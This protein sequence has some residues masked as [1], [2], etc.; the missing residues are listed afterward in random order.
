M[1]EYITQSAFA[2][3]CG[4]SRQALS[5]AIREG[6]VLKTSRGI[7]PAN[8]ANQYYKSEAG[9]RKA[10]REVPK[11]T[12]KKRKKAAPKKVRVKVAPPE[13]PE[14]II[15]DEGGPRPKGKKGS[16][17]DFDLFQKTYENTRLAKIKADMA[18][19]DYAEKIGAVVDIETLK[20]KMNAFSSF[21]FTQLVYLPENIA[22]DLWMSARADEDPERKIR[23]ILSKSIHKLIEEAKAAAAAVLPPDHGVKYVML[24][25]EEEEEE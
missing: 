5:K 10:L 18:V 15:Y 6:R 1:A 14:E 11:K 23:Q 20:Q 12:T 3:E 9:V 19:I 25:L 2:R 24:G 4:V 22:V 13:K 21:L 17:E 16:R 8:P 7:D